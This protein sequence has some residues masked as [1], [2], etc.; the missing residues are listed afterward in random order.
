MLRRTSLAVGILA[1][2]KEDEP[3]ETL[4]SHVFDNEYPSQTE[5]G[6]TQLGAFD[7][8]TAKPLHKVGKIAA[9]WLAPT[10]ST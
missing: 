7:R 4:L 10:R 8:Q 2:H 6:V 1:D 3:G 5:V 9:S